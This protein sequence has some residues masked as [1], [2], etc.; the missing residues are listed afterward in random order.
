L[1]NTVVDVYL[2][3]LTG[4]ALLLALLTQAVWAVGLVVI[5]QL[6]LRTAVKRLVILG[7]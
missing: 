4:E 5:G 2:G 7:G 6:V 3:I 1:L